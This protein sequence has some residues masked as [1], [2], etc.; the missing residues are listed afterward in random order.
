MPGGVTRG[1]IGTVRVYREVWDIAM[2]GGTSA[3][4]ISNTWATLGWVGG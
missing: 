3:S 1:L 4:L 2:A